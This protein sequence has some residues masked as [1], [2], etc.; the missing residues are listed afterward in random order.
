[1]VLWLVESIL[2]AALDDMFFLSLG[3]Q[4]FSAVLLSGVE[5]VGEK[6]PIWVLNRNCTKTTARLSIGH[7]PVPHAATLPI[8]TIDRLISHSCSFNYMTGVNCFVLNTHFYSEVLNGSVAP[9]RG[10][11]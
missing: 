2:K 5:L 3:R 10:Q 8:Q 1:M 7:C 11:L 6:F 4:T 9:P